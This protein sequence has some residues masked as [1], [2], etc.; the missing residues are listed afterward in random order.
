MYLYCI[1][2]L[3]NDKKPVQELANAANLSSFGFFVRSSRMV[4]E[5]TRV[6]QR[7]SF[8]QDNYV[9]HSYSACEGIVGVI[10][11]DKEYPVRV[12]YT[13]LSKVL[14]E[15]L[16]KYPSTSWPE[17]GNER[18]PFNVLNEY[19]I[20]Y[21]DPKNADNII[22]VQ[23]E[24]DDIKN[25]L[26][27]TIDSVLQRGEKLD[28]LVQR[29]D[30]LSAQS[31]LFYKQTYNKDNTEKK[32]SCEL[33]NNLSSELSNE[34][35]KTPA[36]TWVLQAFK[37]HFFYKDSYKD[38]TKKTLYSKDRIDFIT[39][40][41]PVNN[42]NVIQDK[43]NNFPEIEQNNIHKK[44][45]KRN[46]QITDIKTTSKVQQNSILRTPKTN[47]IRKTV[48]FYNDFNHVN[49]IHYSEK[50]T[51]FSEKFP[52]KFPSPYIFKSQNLEKN[53]TSQN[54]KNS[55]TFETVTLNCKKSLMDILYQQIDSLSQN[56]QK[57]ELL[58]SEFCEESDSTYDLQ[59]NN[60][61]K[62]NLSVDLEDSISSIKYWKIKFETLNIVKKNLENE[63]Q[64]WKSKCFDLEKQLQK[65]SEIGKSKKN[66]ELL[67]NNY[68][69]GELSDVNK[70]LTDNISKNNIQLVKKS[71]TCVI[72]EKINTNTE[73]NDLERKKTCSFNSLN[74]LHYLFKNQNSKDPNANVVIN[75]SEIEEK[76]GLLM[77]S[78]IKNVF[79]NQ[80]K[81]ENSNNMFNT[82]MPGIKIKDKVVSQNSSKSSIESEKNQEKNGLNIS[83]KDISNKY[84][85]KIITD[86][87]SQSFKSPQKLQEITNRTSKNS[88]SPVKSF[89]NTFDLA[90]RRAA[91]AKRLEERRKH[92]NESIKIN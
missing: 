38:S 41:T 47:S 84:N 15:F 3:R 55:C 2:I 61:T 58:V 34:I 45:L 44:D 76:D 30:I 83:T 23:K 39:P 88:Q 63:I 86:N 8:D 9:I 21:Q 53:Q 29:S 31:R 81:F 71:N 5:E 78:D 67:E 64:F 91:A 60:S 17:Q 32:H 1:S 57:L 90:T 42:L 51:C 7:K 65:I 72:T 43:E 56:N 48:S 28:D 14:D 35:Q 46:N 18:L 69:R 79:L 89:S 87:I 19:I 6:G 92:K 22:K 66:Q 52:G 68:L 40:K 16:I 10:V 11:S 36:T 54:T 24:L 59:K 82:Y 50:E 13:L 25:V 26:F 70:K 74:N 62:F 85:L 20:K 33:N 12:A 4:A 73:L 80:E 77:K 27:Q 37:N 75:C 49:D